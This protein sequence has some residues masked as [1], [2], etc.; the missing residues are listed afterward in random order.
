MG[1]IQ[2]MWN[3]HLTWPL[4]VTGDHGDKAFAMA[5]RCGQ[6]LFLAAWGHWLVAERG[7]LWFKTGEQELNPFTKKLFDKRELRA[8]PLQYFV[9]SGA[10]AAQIELVRPFARSPL[11]AKIAK[12]RSVH[13]TFSSKLKR[14]T[15]LRLQ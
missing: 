14:L 4:D 1:E 12:I 3:A 10:A 15:S 6:R 8:W 13:Y 11:S 5:Q 9:A 7:S 2:A